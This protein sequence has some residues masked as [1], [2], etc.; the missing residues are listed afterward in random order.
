MA[1]LNNSRQAL[2]ANTAPFSPPPAAT[3]VARQWIIFQQHI[4]YITVSPLARYPAENYLA[5]PV[6]SAELPGVSSTQTSSR[7]IHDQLFPH[8]GTDRISIHPFD[9][10]AGNQKKNDKDT[11]IWLTDTAIT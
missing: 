6:P 7:K 3:A 1:A 8:A 2:L 9:A 5:W 11:E 10:L 4:L